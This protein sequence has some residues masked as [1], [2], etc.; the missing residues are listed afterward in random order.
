MRDTAGVPP[1]DGLVPGAD[2]LLRCWWAGD[3]AEYQRYHDEEWGRPLWGERELFELLSLEGFQA[4]LS[5]LTILRKRPAFRAAFAA[6]E[7]DVVAD[8]DERDVERLLGNPGVVRHRGKITAVIGNA[9]DVV[10]LR[11]E[12]GGLAR[13]VW[14]Y[15]PETTERPATFDHATL[16]RLAT[17][18]SAQRL[19]RDLK[20]RGWAVRRPDERCTRSCSRGGSSTTTSTVAPSRDEIDAG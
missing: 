3:D 1:V 6:F 13:F 17:T 8:F 16:S 9:R 15:A 14:R 5:W 4:G 18:A 2:G 19:S 7:P 12:Q 11:T 10:A 20:R